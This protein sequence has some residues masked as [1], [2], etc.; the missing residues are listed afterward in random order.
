MLAVSGIKVRRAKTNI[1][2]ICCDHDW[3]GVIDGLAVVKI[4]PVFALI[5]SILS[6]TVIM[7]VIFRILKQKYIKL[8]IQDRAIYGIGS[9]KSLWFPRQCCFRHA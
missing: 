1:V 7:A 4:K 5:R 8:L 2:V 6:M 3:G 9:E